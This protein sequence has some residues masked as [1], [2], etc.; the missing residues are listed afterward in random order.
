[1]AEKILIIEDDY[2]LRDLMAKQLVKEG[3][4]VFQAVDGEKGLEA[5]KKEIPDLILLDLILPGMNGFEVLEKIKQDI[6]LSKIV[7]MVL[8]NLAQK[9]DIDKALKLGAADYLVKVNFVPEE[10]IEKIKSIL[11]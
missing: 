10:I 9:D 4:E 5:A 11:K 1:M 2:F 8:S 7:V 3:Y 6:P